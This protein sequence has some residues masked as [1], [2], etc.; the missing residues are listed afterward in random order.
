MCDR[1]Q[2]SLNYEGE[3]LSKRERATLLAW[4]DN[5]CRRH[6]NLLSCQKSYN[7]KLYDLWAGWGRLFAG[8]KFMA[9]CHTK[10]FTQARA[11][12]IARTFISSLRV[13]KRGF[14]FSDRTQKK[15]DEMWL[16]EYTCGFSFDLVFCLRSSEHP[17]RP[18]N[19]HM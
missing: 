12:G 5:D 3:R 10:H 18:T 1:K 15:K 2:A 19:P 6:D 11:S 13:M 7:Y 9:F 16:E 8:R 17:S 14:L 4:D